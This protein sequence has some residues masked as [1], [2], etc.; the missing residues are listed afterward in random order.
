MNTRLDRIERMQRIHSAVLPIIWVAIAYLLLAHLTG[1]AIAPQKSVAEQMVEREEA[2]GARCHA[3]IQ[4]ECKE[5][6]VTLCKAT[7][8]Q[9]IFAPEAAN[10]GAA[11]RLGNALADLARTTISPEEKEYRK[12]ALVS[13]YMAEREA[14]LRQ[15]MAQ[16]D[17]RRFAVAQ[18]I[19][20]N[21]QAT[22]RNQ[23][24]SWNAYQLSHPQIGIYG[25][26][27]PLMTYQAPMLG[28]MPVMRWGR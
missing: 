13:Q 21:M 27:G 25:Y 22:Q 28:A 24:D 4:R 7:L 1:C 15:I 9:R 12:S 6:G 18:A 23:V 16:D 14:Y 19:V 26:G 8:I 11:V 17:A 3:A 10:Q 2:A 5:P 20:G